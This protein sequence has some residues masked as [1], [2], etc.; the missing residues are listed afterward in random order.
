MKGVFMKIY[1]YDKDTGVL[2]SVADAQ[3]NPKQKG[4]FL[5]PRNSTIVQPPSV[6]KNEI[7]V[8]CNGFWSVIPD[9]RGLEQ[10]NV[11]TKEVS[12]VN[13]IG[14][15]ADGFR[16]YSE[17]ILTPEYQ[18]YLLE[19]ERQEKYD[20]ILEEIKSLDEKRVRAICEP[21]IKDITTGET[22]LEYYNKQVFELRQRLGEV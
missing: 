20:S 21:S 16:L 4:N 14:E 9:Y 19:L 12:E 10:I 5:M 17:Y 18:E 11:E 7:A 22:W 2:L 6:Q 13:R 8:F 1:N 3:E 15:L